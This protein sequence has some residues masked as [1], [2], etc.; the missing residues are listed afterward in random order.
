MKVLIPHSRRRYGS[1]LRDHCPEHPPLPE[2]IRDDLE[3]LAGEPVSRQIGELVCYRMVDHRWLVVYPGVD[4]SRSPA[5]VGVLD[6]A[7]MVD[8]S[9]RGL[10]AYRDGD[11]LIYQVSLSLD[12]VDNAT[13]TGRHSWVAGVSYIRFAEQPISDLR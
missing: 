1:M 7:P 2:F 9:D 4:F 11:K 12:S 10:S 3:T 5:I 8:R 6:R 13:F